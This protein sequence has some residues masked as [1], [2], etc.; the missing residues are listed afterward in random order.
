[1]QETR[2]GKRRLDI[3]KRSHKPDP[4]PAWVLAVGHKRHNVLY[5]ENSPRPSILYILGPVFHWI[6]GVKSLPFGKRKRSKF[7]SHRLLIAVGITKD[8]LSLDGS[9]FWW[10]QQRPKPRCLIIVFEWVAGVGDYRDLLCSCRT[11]V[12]KG[13]QYLRWI[14]ACWQM[15]SIQITLTAFLYQWI[16]TGKSRDDKFIWGQSSN[17]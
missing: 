15:A 13:S 6:P 16:A 14:A 7:H 5:I 4:A 12:N 1:M 9:E 17:G 10:R 2:A 8:R 3:V 11:F